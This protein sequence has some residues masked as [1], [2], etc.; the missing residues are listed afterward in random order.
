V[1]DHRLNA[2]T[3]RMNPVFRFLYWNMN[4]HIEHHMFPMVPYHALPKLHEAIRHDTPAPCKSTLHA[5]AE[6]IAALIRQQRDP[7]YTIRR[8]LPA[9]ASPYRPGPLI[10]TPNVV[11][12]E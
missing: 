9:G 12:A 8:P 7:G 4:Y 10:Q 6:I 3:V 11:L 2:R 5:F 1:F